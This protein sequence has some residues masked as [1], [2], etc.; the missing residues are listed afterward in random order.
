MSPLFLLKLE[1]PGRRVTL[2]LMR[3]EPLTAPTHT[4]RLQSE[5]LRYRLQKKREK[6]KSFQ[7]LNKRFS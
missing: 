1:S 2:I 3:R 6:K 5:R 7:K 4:V